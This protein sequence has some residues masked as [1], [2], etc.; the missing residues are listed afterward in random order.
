MRPSQPESDRLYRKEFDRL[1]LLA[2]ARGIRSFAILLAGLAGHVAQ[3]QCNNAQLRH[4]S[5]L[6]WLCM[7]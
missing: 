1:Q 5:Q 7:I 3:D 2:N 4:D 6:S